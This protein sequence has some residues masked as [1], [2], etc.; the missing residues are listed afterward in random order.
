MNARVKDKNQQ[1]YCFF[2]DQ[3][4][5]AFIL[6]N[7][8]PGWLWKVSEEASKIEGVKIARA[9]TG[10]FDVI[11]YAELVKMEDL[12]RLV[13]NLQS[14]PGVIKSQTSIAMPLSAYTLDNH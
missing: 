4:M 1:F 3:V 8:N 10:Q 2:G 7:T 5:E 12:S 14:I 11:I 6:I 9:V 13:E